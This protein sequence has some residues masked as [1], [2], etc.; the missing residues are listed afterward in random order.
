MNSE[1]QQQQQQQ[2]DHHQ[3]S[4]QS[5]S[6]HHHHHQHSNSLPKTHQNP[7]K[8]ELTIP[9]YNPSKKNHH[10]SQS[11]QQQ[12]HHHHQSN[13][14]RPRPVTT[15]ITPVSSNNPNHQTQS[16]NH[17]PPNMPVP[18]TPS[19]R[20]RASHQIQTSNTL[21]NTST[22]ENSS[23]SNSLSMVG[24]SHPMP[25]QRIY[26]GPYLLLQTL[27]EGEF[28]KVKLGV[29][30]SPDRW[31]EE[32]AIKLIKRGNVD[33]QARMIKVAREIDVLK[34]VKHPNIVRLYDVIETE[35][36]IGIVLE[37][38]SG[39][40]LFDH[41]LAHRYLKEKDASKL[42]AQL[43]SGDRSNDLMATSCGSPCYAAPEL[44]VQDGRYVGSQVDVWSCGV[45]L[46]AMLAGYLPFDDDPSNPDGDNINL[47]YKYIIN[48]PLSFPEWIT[49]QPKDLLLRMLVPDPL[50]RCALSEVT[51]HPWLAKYAHLFD[52]SIEELELISE[53]NEQQ[54]RM[55]LQAQRQA[56]AANNG[57][58]GSGATSG[59]SMGRSQS[60]AHPSGI[61]GRARAHQSA[62]VVPTTSSVAESE[63]VQSPSAYQQQRQ[64]STTSGSTST[65]THL[66]PTPQPTAPT[67][68]TRRA[69]AQSAMVIPTSTTRQNKENE[70]LAGMED[71]H[72][73]H[74]ADHKKPVELVNDGEEIAS[75]T[76]DA[77]KKRKVNAAGVT[78]GSN[79]QRYTVQV[80]Y[81]AT[82]SPDSRAKGKAVERVGEDGM[83][84]TREDEALQTPKTTHRPSRPTNED[85]PIARE[86]RDVV[87]ESTPPPNRTTR[88]S[89]TS[90]NPVI[91]VTQPLAGK[92]NEA[93][94]SAHL[95]F[96]SPPIGSKT[97]T[98]IGGQSN[99][100]PAGKPTHT[101]VEGI[102]AAESAASKKD[103]RHRKGMSTD[104]FLSRL[105][106]SSQQGNGNSAIP[107]LPPQPPPSALKKPTGYSAV[108]NASKNTRRKAL[109]MVV[110]PLSGKIPGTSSANRA[111]RKSAK[112][113]P[114]SPG[115]VTSPT[116]SNA[117][118]DPSR[119]PRRGSTM[120]P[121]SSESTRHNRRMTLA[122][123]S[124]KD[125]THGQLVISSP[126]LINPQPQT[127]ISPSTQILG[128]E[129]VVVDERG[130]SGSPNWSQHTAAGNSTSHLSSSSSKA[131]RVMDWFR[132]KSLNTSTTSTNTTV[133]NS[134][135]TNY[136]ES[137]IPP[138]PFMTDFD[139][140]RKN[141]E[142][143]V[144]NSG[145]VNQ[146]NTSSKNTTKP[147]ASNSSLSTRDVQT[148]G[149]ES[150][151]LVQNNTT[152][153]TSVNVPPQ[154]TPFNDSKLKLHHGA[155]DQ[156]AISSISPPLIMFQLKKILWE[157]GIEVTEENSMKLKAMRRSKK[158]VVAS[159][160]LGV[161][162]AL[163][164]QQQQ[165]QSG[166]T[167]SGSSSIG[168]PPLHGPNGG[169]SSGGGGFKSIFNRKASGM[170]VSGIIDQ[171]G[172]V[173]SGN[174]SNELQPLPAYSDDPSVDSGDD[175]RFTVEITKLRGLNGLYAVDIKR[176]KG[177]LWSFKYL[178]LQ[179]LEKA[180]LGGGGGGGAIG[181]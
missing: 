107:P 47:L 94:K 166:G 73:A 121:G 120:V 178:Y 70:V 122:G 30:S 78:P 116:S 7:I 48:T 72:N 97:I 111:N 44:V 123:S 6:N 85:T 168:V 71:V 61:S 82:P 36:Y 162:E 177:S 157:L 37:Y 164:Q 23:Q 175:V 9:P 156:N 80:E 109:S 132:F 134:N 138:T 150:A 142:S 88:S 74:G 13:S 33:T 40:E 92:E 135:P 41:I 34:L 155:I 84:E 59:D 25:R 93:Q 54:K 17:L 5:S 69:Q 22:D 99:Q 112:V 63:F 171:I 20:N 62:M 10:S 152:R 113:V 172:S 2:Q 11:Q 124:K 114:P 128:E 170:S 65:V 104:R 159:L 117:S 8:S 146:I 102:I 163:Q 165:Q 1:Q 110:E 29:H 137:V 149:D 87:Q 4:T 64:Q 98:M 16:R 119:R 53:D 161:F 108:A 95:P 24:P 90:A 12:Q 57:R 76:K 148:T 91:N 153:S 147:V 67:S 158:K 14:T 118:N 89:N 35:K 75:G 160:G 51:S 66:Q 127:P 21:P 50:K 83:V 154:T 38:A 176:L 3:E 126:V 55:A 125:G 96:P 167:T 28:G 136:E 15:A 101:N 144:G 151:V 143:V 42:F 106:G 81:S 52:R 19:N 105:L 141:G 139:E 79:Q 100:A 169:G 173:G 31:G 130:L 129:T 115:T 39:G 27:G 133:M 68:K 43:I 86:A 145:N 60:A 49:D 174:G 77:S 140:R 58:G 56:M 18:A 179:I 181:V 26:F 131:K 180:E 46:Y 103:S 45:I 32:V